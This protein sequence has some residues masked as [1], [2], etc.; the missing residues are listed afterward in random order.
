[1]L[2]AIAALP[3]SALSQMEGL[4]LAMLLP[5]SLRIVA[6]VGVDVDEVVAELVA[7]ALEVHLHIDIPY[8]GIHLAAKD[9]QTGPLAQVG[10]PWPCRAVNSPG[11]IG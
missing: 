11:V 3:L 4:I 6:V 9:T 1:M 7:Q 5:M 8:L 2:C 10:L